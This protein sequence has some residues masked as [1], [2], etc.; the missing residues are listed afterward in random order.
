MGISLLLQM[1]LRSALNA[2][3]KACLNVVIIFIINNTMKNNSNNDEDVASHRFT[4]CFRV[5]FRPKCLESNLRF[6]LKAP[7]SASPSGSHANM[8]TVCLPGEMHSC[9]P[10]CPVSLTCPP[11]QCRHS[12]LCPTQCV[13]SPSST[14]QALLP[15]VSVPPGFFVGFAPAFW[16]FLG[17]VPVHEV[18]NVLGCFARLQVPKRFI[19]CLVGI[20]GLCN[21]GAVGYSGFC[22]AFVG[23]T[24]LFLIFFGYQIWL[25][26]F[27]DLWGSG[28]WIS[29]GLE[30][31][32]SSC[33]N[34]W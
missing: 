16:G 11:T 22:L 6:C 24:S 4:G 18:L 8:R 33:R 30:V 7:L 10:P 29:K 26:G 31:H 9:E 27:S 19:P 14:C 21:R 17:F 1:S 28:P 20:M 25:G 2:K 13:I 12:C 5:G 23:S 15:V 34:L 3:A 32:L